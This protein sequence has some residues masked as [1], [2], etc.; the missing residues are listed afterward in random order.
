MDLTTFEGTRAVVTGPVAQVR[1]DLQRAHRAG[2][3]AMFSPPTPVGRGQVEVRVQ[4]HPL[5]GQRA[6]PVTQAPVQSWSRRR[7]GLL[8]AVAAAVLAA[9]AWM[10]VLLLQWIADHWA[11]IV[12]AIIVT[13]VLLRVAGREVVH[14]VVVRCR[15]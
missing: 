9:L 15:R 8:A 11:V 7:I 5:P 13:V 10:T 14:V 2:R 1:A 6:A 3:L 12:A 4:L